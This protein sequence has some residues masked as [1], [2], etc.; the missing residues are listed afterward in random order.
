MKIIT[1]PWKNNFLELVSN[2][3]HSIKITS[4]FVKENVCN[5]MLIA[6]SSNVKLELITSF[7]LGNIH[8][9]SLDIKA[10]ENIIN[11]DGIVKN[12]SKLHSKI[13]LFDDKE[14]IISSGNLTNG[15]LINNFEYGVYTNDKAIVSQVVTDFDLISKNEKTGPIEP[16]HIAEV[17]KI[18]SNIAKSETTKFPKFEIE[19]QEDKNDVIQLSRNSITQSLNGWKL[20]VFNCIDSIEK[21]IFTLADVY[22]F[23]EVL[24]Q[25]HVTNTR[26]APKIRQQLQNLR[27]IGLLEFLGNGV[28]RKLWK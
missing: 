20:D 15:G 17:N 22:N 7:K 9:G 28:Y 14:V 25:K 6:K 11:K 21:E 5:E 13:Y 27:D 8:S 1:T 12:H 23:E 2:S 18:L 3:K 26:I 24:K 19:N 16:R 4:P 10:I